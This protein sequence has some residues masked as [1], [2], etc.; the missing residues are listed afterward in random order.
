MTELKVVRSIQPDKNLLPAWELYE[1]GLWRS[2]LFYLDVSIGLVWYG[3]VNSTPAYKIT[4][5][6]HSRRNKP[7]EPIVKDATVSALKDIYPTVHALVKEVRHI[8]V[9]REK[10]FDELEETLRR[11]LDALL[12]LAEMRDDDPGD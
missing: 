6:Y 11:D 4:A 5:T 2:S 1:D 12:L 7:I 8:F 9:V 10:H 3:D